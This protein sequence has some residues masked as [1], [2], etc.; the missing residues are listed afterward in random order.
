MKWEIISWL[1]EG[2]EGR[3]RVFVKFVHSTLTT[4]WVKFWSRGVDLGLEPNP[5]SMIIMAPWGSCFQHISCRLFMDFS[6]SHWAWGA[7]LCLE[8]PASLPFLLIPQTCQSLH[9]PWRLINQFNLNI[10]RA[11]LWTL[12]HPGE[13]VQLCPQGTAK[14]GLN[15][16]HLYSLHFLP[17]KSGDWDYSQSSRN[18]SC[19]YTTS[20]GLLQTGGRA[21]CLRELTD[22]AWAWIIA[23]YEPL[24][25]PTKQQN[26]LGLVRWR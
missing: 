17:W 24:N 25:F 22:L 12:D 26:A 4:S 3:F 15:I 6:G 10:T 20:D 19:C 8:I 11:V 23:T 1:P 7:H 14:P 13:V 16:Y 21:L 2:F 9:R 5:P 18:V